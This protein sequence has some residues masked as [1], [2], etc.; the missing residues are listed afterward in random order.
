MSTA[1]LRIVK[2]KKNFGGLTAVNEPSFEV[3]TGSITALIGPNGSGKTTAFNLITRVLNADGGAVYF[4]GTDITRWPSYRIAQVGVGRTFQ[5]SRV[6][7]Q[8]TLWENMLVVARGRSSAQTRARAEALLRLVK[9]WDL[10]EKFAADTSYGQQKLL[11]FA[12][13]LMLNPSLIMLDEPF[14]GVNPTM[15]Q[16]LVALIRQLQGEGKTFFIID[17]AMTIIM[18]LCEKIIVLDMGEKIAE[19]APAVVQNNE[20]VLEAYFGRRNEGTK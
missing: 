7:G 14:A 16:Q 10:R 4:A 6:F 5:I 8:L 13:V 19:G 2:L 15:Q 18:S 20:R 3:A 1:I 11:E 9:L 17:H 12:R